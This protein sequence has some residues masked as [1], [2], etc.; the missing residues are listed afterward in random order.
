MTAPQMRV[1]ARCT[2]CKRPVELPRDGAPPTT[3]GRGR[4]RRRPA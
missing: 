4:C 1:R 3:C 2:R